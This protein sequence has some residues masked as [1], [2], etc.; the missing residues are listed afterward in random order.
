MSNDLYS[1]KTKI[2]ELNNIINQLTMAV[3]NISEVIDSTLL[4]KNNSAT[5]PTNDTPAVAKVPLE[6]SYEDL[7]GALAD[8]SA[9]GHPDEVRMLIR[10]YGG[11]KFSDIQPATYKALSEDLKKLTKEI[12]GTENV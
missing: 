10:K 2:A 7:R 4:E 6:I 5:C 1:I 3:A 9:K 8:L 12:G 11:T